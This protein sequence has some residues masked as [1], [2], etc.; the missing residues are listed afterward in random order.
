MTRYNSIRFAKR[1][2]VRPRCTSKQKKRKQKKENFQ[3]Y[4]YKYEKKRI[5]P[6]RKQRNKKK[7]EP[8]NAD[9]SFLFLEFF[10]SFFVFVFFLSDALIR[11][12]VSFLL[13]LLLFLF[14]FYPPPSSIPSFPLPF[15]LPPLGT[16]I[17]FDFHASPLSFVI[18]QRRH[19]QHPSADPYFFSFFFFF[20]FQISCF[21]FAQFSLSA[22]LASFLKKKEFNTPI[23]GTN[24]SQLGKTR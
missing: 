20:L 21:F 18:G 6:K 9:F 7:L 2:S 22:S 14:C 24:R 1:N 23:P 3:L 11:S 10:V 16:A 15:L 19:L 5:K 13:L 4:F 8:F 17:H 12:A